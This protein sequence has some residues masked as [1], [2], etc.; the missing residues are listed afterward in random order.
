M[1]DMD[2]KIKSNRYSGRHCFLPFFAL[3]ILFIGSCTVRPEPYSII[4]FTGAGEVNNYSK[5]ILLM[6]YKSDSVNPGA[7]PGSIGD[8][9][10][11]DEKVFVFKDAFSGSKLAFEINDSELYVNGKIISIDI[12]ENEKMIPWFE[13]MNEKDLSALQ[14]ISFTSGINEIYMPYLARLAKVR[15]DVGLSFSGDFSKMAGLLKIFKPL[16]I[17]GPAISKGDYK[18]LA[19]LD[20][21][22]I[23]MVSLNDSIVI[24]PLPALPALEQLYLSDNDKNSSLTNDFLTNNRQIKN[25]IFWNPGSFDLSVLKPLVN[26]KELVVNGADTILNT[27]L[28]NDHK[29]LELL[30]LT[31]DKV[32]F[33]TDIIKLPKLRWMAFSSNTVQEEFSTFTVNH[34]DL[35][36]VEIINNEIIRSLRPLSDLRK[37]YGLSVVDTLTDLSTIKTLT[38]L[39]FLSL[40]DAQLKDAVKRAELQNSLPGTRIVANEGFCLGSGWLLMIIPLVLVLRFFG[41]QK[42]VSLKHVE[43]S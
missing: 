32:V 5:S 3:V 18:E 2:I 11:C 8:L 39:K 27:G 40:P 13:K 24:D 21:L 30:S 12:P 14:F 35:E 37:L 20:K 15:P 26:L 36:M 16:Y 34:P 29:S 41:R 38:N 31:G 28:I 1:N 6:S 17:A 7:V 19:S 33:N 43:R 10:S 25:V 4:E 22:K 9:I 42:G 23:L